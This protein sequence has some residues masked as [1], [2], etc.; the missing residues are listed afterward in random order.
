MIRGLLILLLAGRA[1]AS[2]PVDSMAIESTLSG[3]EPAAR[4]TMLLDRAEEIRRSDPRGA[5]DLAERARADA[6]LLDDLASLG[7]ADINIGVGHL[8]LGEYRKAMEG[9]RSALAFAEAAEDTLAMA[10]ALNNIGVVHFYWGEHDLAAEY[11]LRST[12]FR[13]RLDDPRGLA[14]A[15]NNVAGVLQ[16]A[17]EYEH[18][19]EYYRRSLAMYETD[20]DVGMQAS[21]LNN[22]GLVHYDLQQYDEAM[23]VYDRA[24]EMGRS[25]G[26]E[27]HAALTL[28]NMGMVW[29]KR[30]DF[31]MALVRYR[32]SLAMREKLGDRQGAMVCRHNIGVIQSEQGDH[33]A[34]LANLET[35]LA[36]ARELEVLE[37]ERDALESV[38]L[39]LERAGDDRRALA[40]F[41]EY[42]AADDLLRNQ[43]RTGQMIA[44]QTRFE[45]DLKDR[46]IEVLR[47]DKQIEESRRNALLVG[48][49]LFLLIIVLLFQRYRFQKRAAVQIRR[50]NEALRQAHADLERAA[51]DELAHVS[52][53]ATMGELA[54]AFAHELNQPLAAIRANARAGRNFLD[55]PGDVHGE[56]TGALEDIGDDAGRAQ[57]I[58]AN[59]RRLMRKGEI[60][61]EPVAVAAMVS[62]ALRIIQ[63]EC[64]RQGVPLSFVA[65]EGLPAVQ[66]DRVQLQQVVLNLVQNA[67]AVVTG[68]GIADPTVAVR[69]ARLDDDQVEIAVVDQGPPVTDEVLSDMFEPFFTTRQQGLGMGLAICR[70][71]VEAHGGTLTARRNEGPGLTVACRLPADG[72]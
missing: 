33:Q 49:V 32:E 17:G 1:L 12:R 54:A 35:A 59:L 2:A 56:V 60:R 51:R 13:E 19:L 70:T 26:D 18:A 43:E 5:I 28:N 46:E 4:V 48:A 15:Y 65:A 55:R 16:T 61:R 52:R 50:T 44:A 53:V 9:F 34:A 37:L 3:L 6:E 63:P 66:G 42:K 57:E 25:V 8:L 29:E 14:M 45:V 39:A 11:Y 23:A 27:Q 69:A 30:G 24:L 72:A 62:D 47:K 64:T 7:R 67:T 36:E 21:A 58:I 68:A 22:I 31:D 10:N 20:G 41:K 38:A 40:V 71:I